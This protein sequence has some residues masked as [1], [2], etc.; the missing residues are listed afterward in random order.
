MQWMPASGLAILMG[1]IL[2]GIVKASNDD[3]AIATQE[4]DSGLFTLLLLPV[5]IF[6]AAYHSS[7]YY[8]FLM[9]KPILLFALLGT[10]ISFFLIWP[11]STIFLPNAEAAM[12]AALISAVD[13]V[14]TLSV[15]S[16]IKVEPKLEAFV[17]GEAILNDAIAIA[18]Y[19]AAKEFEGSNA[20]RSIGE[21]LGLF[22]LLVISSVAIGFGVGLL[23]ALAFKYGRLWQVHHVQ[24]EVVI[25]IAF[26]YCSFLI[27]EMAGTFFFFCFFVSLCTTHTH[28]HTHF[29]YYRPEWNHSLPCCGIHN[30]RFCTSQSHCKSSTYDDRI[31]ENFGTRQ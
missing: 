24:S 19:R 27:A 21:N 15:F 13:P 30:E 3:T 26:S 5:I 12:F 31:A 29:I 1:L 17:S 22:V 7:N 18:L 10:L 14:A 6:E 9:L 23:S 20:T 16:E 11:T 2:G 25:F 28:T 4:F 8:V